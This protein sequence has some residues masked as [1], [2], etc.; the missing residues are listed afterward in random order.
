MADEITRFLYQGN[1][2]GVVYQQDSSTNTSKEPT[3]N[4]E[5]VKESESSFGVGVG[6]GLGCGIAIGLG[7]G[8]G[9]IMVTIFS[10]SSP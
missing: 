5:K 7:L 1:C 8:W 4:L 6:V 9:S 2:D 10:C 3:D